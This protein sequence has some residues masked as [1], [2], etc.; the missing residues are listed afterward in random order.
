MVQLEVIALAKAKRYVRW[1]T[2]G[3]MKSAELP[4]NVP[5]TSESASGTLPSTLFWDP[6]LRVLTTSTTHRAAGGPVN[7]HRV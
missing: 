4:S 5:I 3:S 7:R 2:H 6:V 1:L